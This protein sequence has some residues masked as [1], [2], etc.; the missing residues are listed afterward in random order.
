MAVFANTNL[1]IDIRVVEINPLATRRMQ[2]PR[3]DLGGPRAG[4][5]GDRVCCISVRLI[6]KTLLHFLVICE[7]SIIK[8]L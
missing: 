6:C 2:Q 4:E 8:N 1:Y 7:P 5:A 3:P